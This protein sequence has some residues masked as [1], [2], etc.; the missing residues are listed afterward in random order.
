[1]KSLMLAYAMLAASTPNIMDLDFPK[2]EKQVR[3]EEAFNKS[4]GLK[5]FFYGQNSLWAINKKNADRKAR[6]LNWL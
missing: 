6:S 2:R 1:M 4:K 3:D 5:R